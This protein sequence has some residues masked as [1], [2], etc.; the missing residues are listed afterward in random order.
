MVLFQFFEASSHKNYNYFLLL[1]ADAM[2]K[3]QGLQG[4]KEPPETL[5]ALN[6]T[7]VKGIL[8]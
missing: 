5:S 8:A 3:L 1:P 6:P 2:W 4:N 7:D